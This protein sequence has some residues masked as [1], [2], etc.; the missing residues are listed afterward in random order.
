VRVEDI[1]FYDKAKHDLVLPQELVRQLGALVWRVLEFDG[2]E[3]TYDD[4]NGRFLKPLIV[5]LDG[6]ALVEADGRIECYLIEL[7]DA[8]AFQLKA[9]RRPVQVRSQRHA[10]SRALIAAVVRQICRRFA[11]LAEQRKRLLLQ[12]APS[13][14]GHRIIQASP[15]RSCRRAHELRRLSPGRRSAQRFALRGRCA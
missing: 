7:D 1:E 11:A 4:E 9:R 5:R 13:F 2:R 3:S 14:V 10:E 8:A 15:R 6:M 12:G